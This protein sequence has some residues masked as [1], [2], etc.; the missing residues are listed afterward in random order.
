MVLPAKWQQTLT[1]GSS[2]V[3]GDAYS[4]SKSV[5][6]DSQNKDKTHLAKLD[7][8]YGWK[9]N[10]QT[11]VSARYQQKLR[12]FQDTEASDSGWSDLGIFNAYQPIPFSRLWLYHTLNIPTA[13]STYDSSQAFA[14]DAHGTGTWQSG[15]GA[16]NIL[17]GVNW[18]FLTNIE[19]HH[20]FQRVINASDQKNEL[21]PSWGGSF[22]LGVG[23]I[24]W[25]SKWRH[26]LNLTPRFEGSKRILINEEASKSKQSLVWDTGINTTY[27]INA[28]Y[29]IGL[30]YVDQTFVGPARN[31]LLA[32]TLSIIFQSHW[33]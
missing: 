23:Y 32:R 4:G 1:V 29:A 16:V 7:L 25:K 13:R 27:S 24:P 18:D 22:G 5:F 12:Q 20:S 14:V 30:N 2:Q 11:G 26:G 33:L 21:G 19:I 9:T 3:I 8:T 28:N 15:L 31:T 17:N 6:R 10:L